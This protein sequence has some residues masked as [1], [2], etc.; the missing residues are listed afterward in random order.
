[1]V[2]AGL[3]EVVCERHFTGTEKSL[4]GTSKGETM[5]QVNWK[6]LMAHEGDAVLTWLKTTEEEFVR[7]IHGIWLF[8]CT[9]IPE[10][11]RRFIDWLAEKFA[12]ACRFVIRLARLTAVFVAWAAI[13][14]G[15]LVVYASIITVL[16]LVLALAGSVWGFRRQMKRHRVVETFNKEV[17]RARV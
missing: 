5:R 4:L 3:A 6:N 7:M 16:W 10:L 8:I 14:F 15:P 11:F 12:D 2:Q 1:M 13:V 17:Y 9:Q